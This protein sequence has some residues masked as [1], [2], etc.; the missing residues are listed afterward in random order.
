MP[1][2]SNHRLEPAVKTASVIIAFRNE[3]NNLGDLLDSIN[4]Q[5]YPRELIKYI[6]IN[7]HSSDNSLKILE[8]FAFENGNLNIKILHLGQLETGKKTA[9]Q[10]AYQIVDTEIILSTDADCILPNKWIELSIKAFDEEGVQLVCGG[11]KT[12]TG[13]NWLEQFQYVDLMSLI[14]SGAAAIE[15]GKP[16]MSNGANIAF[17]NQLVKELNFSILKQETP[18][19]DDV[20]LLLEVLKKYGAQAIRFQLDAQHWVKTK[21]Q[22]TFEQ[23]V[24]QRIRW[25][26][27]S[28]I[29]SNPFLIFVSLLILLS[30]LSIPFLFLWSL[31]SLNILPSL[32]LFW[33]LK[34]IIDYFFIRKVALL[35]NQPF[36][37][38]EYFNTALIYPFFI[39]YIAIIGQFA[40][41]S[42]KDRVY[43][44]L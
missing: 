31:F 24:Q 42:W 29:Y 23:L 13:E 32:I 19:G 27:K 1:A 6:F 40:S 36:G 11:V 21:T 22:Q 35:S 30:N 37:L 34:M 7:D 28:K 43:K 5:T 15:M 18:S 39:S 8:Q 10:K 17:R 38:T 20:F 44:N 25:T 16:I 41:F 14:G 9:L 4:D 12:N 26:S 2:I 33:L 3:E